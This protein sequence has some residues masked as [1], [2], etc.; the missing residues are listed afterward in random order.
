LKKERREN[1]EKIT[2]STLTTLRKKEKTLKKKK[3]NRLIM[4][5]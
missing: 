2:V 1:G 4:D 5:I 3:H